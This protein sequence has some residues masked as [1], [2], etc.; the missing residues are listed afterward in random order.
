[1]PSPASNIRQHASAP[2]IERKPS[3]TVVK[4][5]VEGLNLRAA[6]SHVPLL[7]DLLD[8][9]ALVSRQLL[10]AGGLFQAAPP[11]AP[12]PL[13]VRA[14]EEENAGLQLQR[15]ASCAQSEEG[16]KEYAA[17]HFRQVR[18]RVGGWGGE[19][20]G[21]GVCMCVRMRRNADRCGACVCVCVL[22]GGG[23]GGGQG[24]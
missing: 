4:L 5:D 23:C 15:L 6:F 9:V 2:A 21:T 22:G 11:L 1:M 16:V 10:L 20:P 13:A 12:Q 17:W 18:A 7:H 3:V 8:D 24:G 14:V 19:G